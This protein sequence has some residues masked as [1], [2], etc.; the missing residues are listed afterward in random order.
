MKESK[1]ESTSAALCT[2][3]AKLMLKYIEEINVLSATLRDEVGARWIMRIIIARV[4]SDSGSTI[5]HKLGLTKNIQSK[6]GKNP[7]VRFV[8]DLVRCRQMLGHALGFGGGKNLLPEFGR[9][10]GRAGDVVRESG[11]ELWRVSTDA[12][13]R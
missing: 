5:S 11:N 3:R 4:V 1:E 13:L 8:H 9:G 10:D 12:S 6:K 7:P 2:S